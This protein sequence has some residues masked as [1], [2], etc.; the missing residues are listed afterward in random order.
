MSYRKISKYL[1]VSKSSVE[2][3]LRNFQTY[4]CIEDFPTLVG[5]PRLLTINDMK[6]LEGLLKER[7]DWY[8]W[9]LQ[10]QMDLW[11]GRK[12]S[13]VTIWRTIHQLGYSHKQVYY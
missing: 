11:L 10:F 13:Y 2:R 1:G 3:V 8:L 12:I 4:G 7:V 6:Y 5:R 9:E